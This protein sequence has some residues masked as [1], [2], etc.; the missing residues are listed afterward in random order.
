M[1]GSTINNG[2]QQVS[3]YPYQQLSSVYGNA[4]YYGNLNPGVYSTEVVITFGASDVVFT[5][6]AGT[7]LIFQRQAIDPIDNTKNDNLIG[8]IVLKSDATVPSTG[9]YP[10]TGASGLWTSAP[11]TQSSALYIVAD[12]EYSISTPSLIYANFTLATD[13]T[14]NSI[15]AADG[16]FTHK[17]IIATILNQQY[18]YINNGSNDPSF[19][20]ISYDFQVNRDVFKKEYI[21]NN[22]YRVDFDGQGRGVYIN[23]GH[24]I[25]GGNVLYTNPAFDQ[26]FTYLDNTLSWNLAKAT[27]SIYDEGHY[28]PDRTYS[29]LPTPSD[30]P[31]DI[32]NII[33]PA[34]GLT[35]YID[36]ITG[37]QINIVG[38]ENNYYQID[39]LRIKRNE[40]THLQTITWESFIRPEGILDFST[41]S[42]IPSSSAMIPSNIMA[43]LLQYDFPVTGD[44][45][46]PLIAIR[47][48]GI[49]GQYTTALPTTDGVTNILWSDSCLF[50][51]ETAIPQFGGTSNHSRF[52]MPVWNA[53]DIGEY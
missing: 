19:Y 8:K 37:S 25:V 39:F 26:F 31:A 41:F 51:N 20:H 46:T 12:W 34:V 14:I 7:T 11:Y 22:R 48:R 27:N 23:A 5:I 28:F 21:K 45:E 53:S 43:Y 38:S 10:K 1:A 9:A 29:G 4:L 44:G 32:S 16:T 18:Y 40:L 35:Y 6:K 50:M 24:A 33:R 15:K 42:K 36:P 13:S 2:Q 3:I 52:K 30:I 49:D 47:P 17:L